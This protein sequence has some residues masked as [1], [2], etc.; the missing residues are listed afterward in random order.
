[1]DKKFNCVL[2]KKPYLI[3]DIIDGVNNKQLKACLDIGHVNAC[4]KEDVLHWIEL[5]GNRIGHVHLHNNFGV[6]DEHNGINNGN[7]DIKAITSYLKINCLSANWNLEIRTNLE[8]SIEL[9]EKYK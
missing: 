1:M 5:L 8:E 4:A 2:E 3:K 7:L 9:I 6:K